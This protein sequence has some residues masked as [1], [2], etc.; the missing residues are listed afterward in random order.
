MPLLLLILLAG[1]MAY[2]VWRSRT[3]SLSRNCRWRQQKAQD[4]WQCL[5]CGALQEGGG[6]PRACR[7]PQ[8]R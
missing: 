4:R 3:S 5:Y 1:V 6:T 2:F 7:N 8:T